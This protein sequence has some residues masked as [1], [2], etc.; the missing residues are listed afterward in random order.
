MNRA[1]SALLAGTLFVLGAMIAVQGDRSVAIRDDLSRVERE[2][3]RKP[4][5]VTGTATR[6]NGTQVT[7][8]ITQGSGEWPD[9][10]PARQGETAEEVVQRLDAWLAFWSAH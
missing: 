9:G 6:Q 8:S 7:V 1:I 4:M 10:T 3:R 2:I 5:T